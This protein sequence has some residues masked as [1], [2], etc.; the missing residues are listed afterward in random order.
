MSIPVTNHLN[1]MMAHQAVG[2]VASVQL[3]VADWN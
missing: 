3:Q 2:I 1:V